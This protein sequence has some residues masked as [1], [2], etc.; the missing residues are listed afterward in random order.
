MLGGVAVFVDEEEVPCRLGGP[1]AGRVGGDPPEVHASATDLDEE[2]H[3]E[4]M[5][6]NPR[7]LRQ[8]NN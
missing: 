3:M 1:R 6:R 5:V 8:M 7:N 4:T 2:Q